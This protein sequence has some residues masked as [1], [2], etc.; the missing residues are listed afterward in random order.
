MPNVTTIC[1]LSSLL[2]YGMGYSKML[3]FRNA[4]TEQVNTYDYNIYV[5]LATGY[6][7]LAIFF[8]VIGS[9]FFYV[10]NNRVQEIIEIYDDIEFRGKAGRESDDRRRAS[11]LQVKAQ[12]TQSEYSL[13]LDRIM[14]S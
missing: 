7:V 2:F 4:V 13:D 6:F 9:L 5:S 1:Y 12:L 10:K 14:S 11:I 3:V 8:A